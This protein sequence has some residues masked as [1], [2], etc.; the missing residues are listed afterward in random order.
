M[1][2]DPII[3]EIRQIRRNIEAEYDNNGDKFYEHILQIQQGYKNRLVHRQP[4]ASLK[5][6]ESVAMS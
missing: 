4:K 3:R 5:K 2:D 1:F 6:R